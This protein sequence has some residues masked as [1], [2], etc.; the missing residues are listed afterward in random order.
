M[1]DFY[2]KAVQSFGYCLPGVP[3][4]AELYGTADE[5]YFEK[6]AAAVIT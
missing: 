3:T 2:V 6:Y 5:Q 4:F 1:A